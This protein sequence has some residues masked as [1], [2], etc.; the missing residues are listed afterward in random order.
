MFHGGEL[1]RFRDRVDAGRD[2]A[3]RLE[4]YRGKGT[5]VL[6]IP[7]GGVA[8]AAEIARRLDA[9]LD[10][11]VA[12]K[13]GA[14]GQAEL[15]I[16][17]VTADGRRFLND[18]VIASLGVSHTYLKAVTEVQMREAHQRELRYRNRRPAVPLAGRVVIVVDDG[19]ATGATM[20]ASLRSVR[21]SR[22]SRLIAAVPVGST[23]ACGTVRDEVD[24]LICPYELDAFGAV[25]FYYEEF[26]AVE[27]AEVER[28][29]EQGQ[30]RT[31]PGVAVPAGVA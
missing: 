24:E 11:I 8:V 4:M 30:T 21:A 13:L 7:R 25:G 22:P 23:Q 26:R 19:L 12:R 29:L 5:V 1:P 27:D 20:R 2:L 31:E 3:E 18:D 14:P 28:L 10:V 15:A 9:Q 17:A 16:G 6:G